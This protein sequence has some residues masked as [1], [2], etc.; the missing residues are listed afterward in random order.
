MTCGIY[1]IKNKIDGKMYIGQAVNI[2]KRWR[3]H[4]GGCYD[5]YIDRA[6]QKYGKDN[7][8][9]IILRECKNDSILLNELEQYYIK[10]YNT[11]EDKYHYNLTPGGDFCPAKVP[12]IAKKISEDR[13]SVV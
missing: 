5:T 12:E 8:E 9:L 3:Q 2:E 10:K 11:Y 13:K 6:I 1:M 4:C 7:F